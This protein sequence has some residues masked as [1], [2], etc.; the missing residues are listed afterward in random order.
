[1]YEIDNFPDF[2]KINPSK[3]ERRFDETLWDNPNLKVEAKL[4]SVNWD[5]DYGEIVDWTSKS[6]KEDYFAQDFGDQQLVLEPDAESPQWNHKN[7]KKWVE[8]FNKYQ[9]TIKIE[10]PAESV[11]IF[12]YLVVSYKYPSPV[13]DQIAPQESYYFFVRASNPVAPNTSELFLALDVWTTYRERVDIYGMILE[14]GHNP[15]AAINASTFLNN[16]INSTIDL[17][18]D[19]PDLPRVKNR[20]NSVDLVSINGN[21]PKVCIATT[22]D[23]LNDSDNLWY[24]T[25]SGDPS[26]YWWEDQSNDWNNNT[27]VANVSDQNIQLSGPGIRV[28]SILPD[29]YADFITKCRSNYPQFIKTIKAVYVLPSALISEGTNFNFNGYNLNVVTTQPNPAKFGELDINKSAFGYEIENQEMAKLYTGQFAEI[30][31]SDNQGGLANISVEE[32]AGNLDVYARA[33]ASFPFLKMEAFIDG[34]GGSG[35]TSF[36][37]KP[38]DTQTATLFNSRFAE[39]VFKMDIPVY[40]IFVDP[41]EEN[42]PLNSINVQEYIYKAN[43]EYLIKNNDF[44]TS[45]IISTL[46]ANGKNYITH[47]N[48]LT[49]RSISNI[50]ANGRNLIE[51][52]NALNDKNNSYNS[53]DGSNY[54]SHQNSQ[55]STD[56]ANLEL[57]YMQKAFL[58]SIDAAAITYSYNANFLGNASNI[59]KVNTDNIAVQQA[60]YGAITGV[61]QAGAMGM[62]GGP[63]GAAFG[64]ASSMVG[65]IISIAA[66]RKLNVAQVNIEN[67]TATLMS[68][69]NSITYGVNESDSSRGPTNT[70]YVGS[71][72]DP[73]GPDVAM[74][75]RPVDDVY[76]NNNS[77]V[78]SYTYGNFN[79]QVD[80]SITLKGSVLELNF[81]ERNN[82]ENAKIS[83]NQNFSNTISD[84]SANM[85]NKPNVDNSYN[86]SINN[87]DYELNSIELPNITFEY[88]NSIN[89][90]D[91]ELNSIE[92]P[93]IISEYNN[94]INNANIEKALELKVGDWDKR[95]TLITEPSQYSESSGPGEIDT[96]GLR[97]LTFTI[98]T[99]SKASEKIVSNY[100]KLKGY[101]VNSM[102]VENPILSV[103][104]TWSYWKASNIWLNAS[105]ISD[106]DEDIFRNIFI[107]GTRIWRD[108]NVV[109]NISLPNG[110]L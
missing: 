15:M 94:S 32:L 82:T 69:S 103:M 59:L 38:W 58:H 99:I 74:W 48:A 57:S 16:P 21:I 43:Q 28:Y 46:S 18:A 93:N 10:V 102:L 104:E 14:Q 20:T 39:F 96:W 88:N 50:S 11:S 33:S 78:D 84:Y 107:G 8:A 80:G 44:T 98:N 41:R 56:I 36:S 53:I 81:T 77:L 97:G 23:L 108:P 67:A 85:I 76:L 54:I 2:N 109:K 75:P 13:P 70:Y 30:V 51:H 100:F 31:I 95:K 55:H 89:N 91:Y 61:A 22:T 37:V 6:M 86:N 35:Q 47:Q 7:F 29:D 52:N 72:Q 12:N 62:I 64:M 3:L 40:G 92:L 110:V 42:G 17:T 73:S 27:A 90:A 26:A 71:V 49:S 63:E 45:K 24:L 4:L 60:Q 9:G 79:P 105:T 83:S 101:N 34:I 87:I 1:M 25:R 19:E 5:S 106:A 68:W 65:G 66:A